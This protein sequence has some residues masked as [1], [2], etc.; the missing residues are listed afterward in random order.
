[1]PLQAVDNRRLYRQ[2][3]DQIAALI[4]R[5]EYGSGQRLPPE[6]DLAK[7]LGVS[8]PSVREALIALEV[9]GLVEGGI[10]SGLVVLGRGRAVGWSKGW[11]KCASGRAS[12]CWVRGSPRKVMSRRRVARTA[13]RCRRSPVRSS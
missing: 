11:S 7:Q 10:G 8:R 12:M 13:A 9:E 2:I 5:G 1:M 4:E 3:A 6:R